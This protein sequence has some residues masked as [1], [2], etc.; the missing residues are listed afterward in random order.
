MS[1]VGHARYKLLL[2]AVNGIGFDNPI[3]ESLPRGSRDSEGHLYS[4][5]VPPR[6]EHCT[7]GLEAREPALHKERLVANFA[8]F[9]VLTS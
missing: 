4:G 6:Y 8:G 9:L 1:E 3:T 2:D 5:Q 7:Q